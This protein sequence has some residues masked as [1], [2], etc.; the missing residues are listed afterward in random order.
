MPTRPRR[1]PRPIQ[2]ER[3][4]RP[5]RSAGKVT[6]E[7]LAARVEALENGFEGVKRDVASMKGDVA[8]VRQNVAGLHGKLDLVQAA[9]AGWLQ[10][11]SDVANLSRRFDRLGQ[12]LM[13]G[14]AMVIVALI[15][16][17]FVLLAQIR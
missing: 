16:G 1:A 12:L 7:A 3:L 8:Q 6:L 2:T 15:G 9:A 11:R 10:V 14:M 5:E 13:S 17:V 4:E